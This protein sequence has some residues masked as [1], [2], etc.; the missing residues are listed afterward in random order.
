MKIRE[1]L[2]GLIFFSLSAMLSPAN[3]DIASGLVGYYPLD[4]N[5]KDQSVSGNNRV[6]YGAIPTTESLCVRMR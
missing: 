1:F 5:A 4:G 2:T 6:I 3:A